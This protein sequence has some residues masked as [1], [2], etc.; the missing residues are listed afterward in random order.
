MSSDHEEG[1]EMSFRRT[2]R[3][4][5]VVTVLVLVLLLL[6]NLLPCRTINHTTR[7]THMNIEKRSSYS[8]VFIAVIFT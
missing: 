4:M 5:M 7:E 8:R 3:I 2:R 6:L 1:E